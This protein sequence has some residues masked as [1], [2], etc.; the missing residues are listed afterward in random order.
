MIRHSLDGFGLVTLDLFVVLGIL[1]GVCGNLGLLVF[2]LFLPSFQLPSKLAKIFQVMQFDVAVEVFI[3]VIRIFWFLIL[4]DKN[5]LRGCTF[6]VQNFFFRISSALGFRPRKNGCVGGTIIRQGSPF[7]DDPFKVTNKKITRR[8]NRL[9][10]LIVI[11]FKS[12]DS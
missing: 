4:V 2:Q 12:S 6:L 8:Q 11:C 9:K 3:I 7:H 5:Q 10:C 1:G